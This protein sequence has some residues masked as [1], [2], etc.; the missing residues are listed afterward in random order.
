MH[1][2]KV[3]TRQRNDVKVAVRVTL[4][5]VLEHGFQARTVLL[6]GPL[7]EL[8]FDLLPLLRGCAVRG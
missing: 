2:V 4:I 5:D 7:K 1:L 8:S 6:L 3:L